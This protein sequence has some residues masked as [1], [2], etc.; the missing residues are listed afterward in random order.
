VQ[1]FWEDKEPCW[2]VMDCPE[3]VHKKCPAFFNPERPCWEVA[4]T[5]CEFLINILK[6][7]KYCKVYNLYNKF[8]DHPMAKV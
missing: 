5:Q 8:A 1:G 2:E 3:Y 6:D 7:C 4:H